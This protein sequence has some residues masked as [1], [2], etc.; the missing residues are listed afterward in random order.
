MPEI[1]EHIEVTGALGE[2]I[3]HLYCIK[4]DSDFNTI[5]QHLSPSLEIMLAFNFG[6][7]VRISFGDQDLGEKR[8]EKVGVIGPL[9][10]MLN[11]EVLPATDMIVVAFNPNGFYRL[12][13]I[14]VDRM[15]NEM[16][17]DPDSLLGISGF[18]ELWEMLKTLPAQQ[19]RANLLIEYGLAFIKEADAGSQPLLEGILDLENAFNQ[20][21]KA[22][23]V[24][25]DLSTRTI[26][27]RFQKY[28][29][30]S[31]KELTRFVRFKQVIDFIQKQE[32]SVDWLA[33]V[34]EFGYHD[35][36]HL[37]KDFKHYLSTTPRKFVQD[38]LGKEFCVSKPSGD[39]H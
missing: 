37:I 34:T 9:R 2:V 30:F 12:F 10:K 23:A 20:P 25:T 19:S 21:S 36:S 28:L 26:Q 13:Q 16:V 5:T 3:K 6:L 15:Q 33:V 7:P 31:T 35:Q 1:G 39:P 38:F 18:E 4:T 22:I 11:Y 32:H 14:P 27:M 24:E 8:I 29:G 17:H